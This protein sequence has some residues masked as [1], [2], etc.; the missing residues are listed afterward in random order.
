MT[1]AVVVGGDGGAVAA[2][3]A[4][5]DVVAVAVGGAV[6]AAAPPC[7]RVVAKVLD[8]DSSRSSPLMS[9]CVVEYCRRGS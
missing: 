4:A 3:V 7:L 9:L 2:G 8:T 6:G 5:C 1:V